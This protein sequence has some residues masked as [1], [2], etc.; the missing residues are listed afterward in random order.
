M[1]RKKKLKIASLAV[2]A[3]LLLG[4]AAFTVVRIFEYQQT[5]YQRAFPENQGV[6]S[7]IPMPKG[8]RPAG[9]YAVNGERIKTFCT[10]DE[11]KAFYQDY[12]S[13][14]PKVSTHNSTKGLQAYYDEEQQLIIYDKIYIQKEW[15]GLYF[16][17]L[18][19]PYGD[20]AGIHLEEEEP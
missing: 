5:S 13:S 9:P 19:D 4:V 17:V 20:G 8:S 16:S 1:T 15:D 6:I 7:N 18:Y 14:L 10:E 11:I 2:A 3:V 12:F